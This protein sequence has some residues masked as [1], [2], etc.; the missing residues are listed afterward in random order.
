MRRFSPSWG[1]RLAPSCKAVLGVKRHL[2]KGRAGVSLFQVSSRKVHNRCW[3]GDIDFSDYNDGSTQDSN[4]A[5]GPRQPQEE[6]AERRG[7]GSA[8]FAEPLGTNIS[9]YD[10]FGRKVSLKPKER[11]HLPPRQGEIYR[12]FRVSPEQHERSDA[13]KARKYPRLLIIDQGGEIRSRLGAAILKYMIQTS[14][15]DVTVDVASLGPVSTWRKTMDLVKPL[16]NHWLQRDKEALRVFQEPPRQ[17]REVKDPVQYDLILVMDRYD[18]QETLREVSVLDVI[19]PGRF[20][21]SRIRMISSFAAHARNA[22]FLKIPGDI[23]DP[24]FSE[25]AEEAEATSEICS[26]SKDLA[27][28]CRGVLDMISC[29]SQKRFHGINSR[30]AL[31]QVLKCPALWKELP[32]SRHHRRERMYSSLTVRHTHGRKI[33]TKKST[34][35]RGYWKDIANV[36]FELRYE[37]Q[38]FFFIFCVLKNLNT[39]RLKASLY[40]V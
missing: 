25:S 29:I 39:F 37:K 17:F 35:E 5:V 21:S 30:E 38:L 32:R 16:I 9:E 7:E 33:I 34:K 3:R 27:L 15:L 4:L 12:K 22:D 36:E 1:V 26:M 20:Y 24:L 18:L 11:R 23:V 31:H 13:K 40:F 6:D 8:S 10:F 14:E 28:S 2:E 19:S